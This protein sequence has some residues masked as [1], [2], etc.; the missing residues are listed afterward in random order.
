MTVR[1]IFVT[2]ATIA[3]PGD[4]AFNHK[5]WRLFLTLL[6]AL[7]FQRI[8]PVFS[9]NILLHYTNIVDIYY[10]NVLEVCKL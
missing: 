4:N 3:L 8:F 9:S 7:I 6:G 2:V 5:L 10:T 1:K